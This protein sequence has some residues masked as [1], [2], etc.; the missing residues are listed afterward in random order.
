MII[1]NINLF[2]SIASVTKYS[3]CFHPKQPFFLMIN[4]DQVT[5]GTL[6]VLILAVMLLR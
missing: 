2:C 5:R 4:P 6:E 1:L 3:I